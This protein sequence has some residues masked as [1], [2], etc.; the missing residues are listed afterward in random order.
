MLVVVLLT[1]ILASAAVLGKACRVR[2]ALL[3]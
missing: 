2:T 3:T 1:G